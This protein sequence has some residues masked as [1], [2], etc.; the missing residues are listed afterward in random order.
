MNILI[1]FPSRL[2]PNQFKDTLMKHVTMADDL[3]RL[4]FLVS[5]DSNDPTKD[6]YNEILNE[7]IKYNS[8]IDNH[9]NALVCIGESKSKI[10]AVN[11]DL[12]AYSVNF[13]NHWDIS[14]VS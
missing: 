14:S 12:E 10:D 6:Q 7:M 1:K 2:R 9:I 5:L 8:S 3:S 11:R 4:Y 13:D